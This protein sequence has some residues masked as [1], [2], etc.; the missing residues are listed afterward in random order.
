[1]ANG[2]QV[3]LDA[4]KLLDADGFKVVTCTEGGLII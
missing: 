4:I 1:M 2:N 3:K